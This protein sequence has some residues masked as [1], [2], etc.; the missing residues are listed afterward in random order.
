MELVSWV[1]QPLSY[2]SLVLCTIELMVPTYYKLCH[3]CS[4][5]GHGS[6]WTTISCTRRCFTWFMIQI[7]S[8][9]NL[10]WYLYHF[11]RPSLKAFRIFMVLVLTHCSP[12][13]VGAEETWLVLERSIY[14]LQ[15]VIKC[16]IYFPFFIHFIS[17]HDENV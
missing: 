15:Q 9:P 11:Y 16:Q 5:L 4:K 3:S 12:D 13:M 2:I 1:S 8:V 17:F 10:I 6:Q 7:L 14:A